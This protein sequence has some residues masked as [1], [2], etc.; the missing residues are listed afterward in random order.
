MTVLQIINSLFYVLIYPYLI[1]T[2]GAE[3]YGLYIYA[4]SIVTYFIFIINFGFDLPATKVVAQ[5]KDNTTAIS[6]VL[7]CIFT[8]KIYLLFVSVLIFSILLITIPFLKEHYLLFVIVFGQ[9][10]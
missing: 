3:S 1:R 7:S 4:L 10:I 8:A 5:E 6:N 9:T 2:L